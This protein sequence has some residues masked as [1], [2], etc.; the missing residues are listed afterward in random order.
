MSTFKFKVEGKPYQVD[1][2]LAEGNI[3]ELDVNGKKYSVE[4]EEAVAPAP[5]A[6]PAAAP[7]ASAAPVAAAPAPAAPAA[8]GGTATTVKSPLPGSIVKIIATEGTAVKEGDV[9]L[10]M[11]SMKMENNIAAEQAGTIRKVH[12]VQGQAVMQD[13]PLVDIG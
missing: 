1:V 2:L 10:V 8:T 11:E 13:D 7:V 5:V 9:L 4:L 3:L 12:V 6:K